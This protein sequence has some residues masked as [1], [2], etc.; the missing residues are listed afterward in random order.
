MPLPDTVI[1]KVEDIGAK[2]GQGR[3]FRFTNR[4]NELFSWTD[5]V[6]E[7]DKE[8]Q[9]LLEP[10]EALY[11]DISAELPG[12]ELEWNQPDNPLNAVDE[13]LELDFEQRAAGALANAA[14]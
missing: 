11:P 4:K 14:I 5:E 2:E 6:Q 9:G 1:A 13:E 10:E 12:I 8:F 3:D 7:D